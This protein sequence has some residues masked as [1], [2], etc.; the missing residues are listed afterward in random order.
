MRLLKAHNVD[1]S[2]GLVDA[3]PELYYSPSNAMRFRHSNNTTANFLF[4][5]GHVESR[6]LGQV[7]AKDIALNPVYPGG[8]WA[9]PPT[10]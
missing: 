7:K 9:G 5:D 4:V 1:D 2:N 3:D 6:V 10:P 8:P